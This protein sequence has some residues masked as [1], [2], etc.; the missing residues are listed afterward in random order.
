MEDKLTGELNF[1][2]GQDVKLQK[3]TMRND[4]IWANV[5]VEAENV[6]I[7]A[8]IIK[9]KMKGSVNTSMGAMSLEADKVVETKD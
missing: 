1:S 7:V 9:S 6:E 2:S 5:Y 3:L 4:T 8:K